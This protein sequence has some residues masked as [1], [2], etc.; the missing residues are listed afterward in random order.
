MIDSVLNWLQTFFIHRGTTQVVIFWKTNLYNVA[1]NSE[2]KLYN[3]F[4]YTDNQLVT[5]KCLTFFNR[6]KKRLV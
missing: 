6:C 4:F 5:T 2:K 1:K 3:N